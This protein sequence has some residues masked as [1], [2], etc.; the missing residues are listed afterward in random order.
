MR[1]G[2]FCSNI[3]Q[4]YQ[5]IQNRT[6]LQFPVS[7]HIYTSELISTYLLWDHGFM[8][9]SIQPWSDKFGV[10]NSGS[11]NRNSMSAIPRNT[12]TKTRG[13]FFFVSTSTTSHA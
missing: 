1:D 10:K 12:N 4:N 3:H 8:L 7:V 2:Q 13:Y 6:K 5:D 11:F 9:N